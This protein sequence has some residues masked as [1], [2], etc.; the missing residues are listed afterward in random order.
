M[1]W[2]KG[3]D[4]SETRIMQEISVEDAA[5]FNMSSSVVNMLVISPLQQR[6]QPERITGREIYKRD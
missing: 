3:G 1:G 2:W 5:Y 6:K 4:L